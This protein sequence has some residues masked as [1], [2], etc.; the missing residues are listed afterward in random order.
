[1]H[2]REVLDAIYDNHLYEYFVIDR[3][4]QIVEFSDKVTHYCAEGYLHCEETDIFDVLPEFI[5]MQKEFEELFEGRKE[6]FLLPYVSKEPNYYINI[7][8]HQGRPRETLI[9]LLEDVTNLA[10]LEQR[11]IQERND[12]SLLLSQLAEK[13]RQLQMYNEQM[14]ELVRQETQKNLQKQKMLELRSRQAQMGEMI[15]MITHQWKQ[16][17]GIISLSCS[18][19]EV[20]Q[21]KEELDDTKLLNQLKDIAKQVSYMNTTVNDFQN[22]FNPSKEKRTFRVR[23]TI[24]GITDLISNDYEINNIKVEISGSENIFANGYQNEYSQ[25]IL[26]ILKNAKDAFVEKPHEDMRIIIDITT[27]DERSF[28]T[29]R[30]NAGGIPEDIIGT[31]FDLY[32]STKEDG[33]GLGLNIAKSVIETN[34]DGKLFARNVENGVE[35]TIVV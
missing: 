32:M 19:L 6:S 27:Q 1:M 23:K 4:Y 13:N 2:L 17:L 20:L 3:E 35:F 15:G 12:K 9:V 11:S 25:V 10:N 14:Q 33:S 29:I 30:D 26:S 7:R 8:V 5:G 24:E 21:R 31:I 28:V 22:F 34:M 16:P 18:L